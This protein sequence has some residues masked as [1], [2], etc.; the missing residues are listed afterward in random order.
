MIRSKDGSLWLGLYRD[1]ILRWDG[2]SWARF[3]AEE[4]VTEK[5]RVW[6]LLEDAQ[7]ALWAANGAGGLLRFDP[8]AGAWK[9]IEFQRADAEIFSISELPD[10]SLW[11]SGNDFIA[12]S[13]D[14]GEH[15]T[16]VATPDGRP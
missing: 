8:E 12:R 9:K 2:K 15:W 5:E 1:G 14:G 13:G 16:L 6:R 10:K 7:G 4:G 11:A 3:G